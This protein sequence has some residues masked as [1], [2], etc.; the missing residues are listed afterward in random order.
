MDADA[1]KI[2]G[3]I[4]DHEHYVDPDRPPMSR[5]NRAAQFSPFAALSGYDDLIG[6]AARQTDEQIEL[7]ES[8]KEEIGRRIDVLLHMEDAPQAEITYFVQDTKKQGGAYETA[9]GKII[10]YE[11]LSRA[12]R[13]DTGVTLSIDDVVEVKADCFDG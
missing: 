6:E 5:L 4:I 1:R 8:N 11:A 13:L 2:Y 3:D 9:F 10:K 12:V 7:D